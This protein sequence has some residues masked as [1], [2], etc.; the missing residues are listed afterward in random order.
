MRLI[1]VVLL[2]ACGQGSSSSSDSAKN[3]PVDMLSPSRVDSHLHEVGRVTTWSR[4]LQE[5]EDPEHGVRCYIALGGTGSGN[6]GRM[7]CIY[8]APDGKV[9]VGGDR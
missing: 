8:T 3:E 5:F 7:F 4:G 2:C 9:Y 1:L 6:D